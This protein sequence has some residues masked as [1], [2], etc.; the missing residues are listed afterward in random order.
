MGQGPAQCIECMRFDQL[1]RPNTKRYVHHD[2]QRQKYQR[3]EQPP[4]QP[5]QRQKNEHKSKLTTHR[6][7]SDR[8]SICHPSMTNFRIKCTSF[9]CKLFIFHLIRKSFSFY[10]TILRV[11]LSILK[12]AGFVYFSIIL[13]VITCALEDR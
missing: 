10:S 1:N 7:H 4:Q 11:L 6:Q 12:L 8:T 3:T 13:N 5:V 2:H 9:G